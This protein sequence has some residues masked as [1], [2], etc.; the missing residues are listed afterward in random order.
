MDGSRA[1]NLSTEKGDGSTKVVRDGRIGEI[2]KPDNNLS[3]EKGDGSTK[4][5]RDGR[6]GEIKKPDKSKSAPGKGH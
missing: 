4:V 2:K 6:I 5:V 1:P 3:T